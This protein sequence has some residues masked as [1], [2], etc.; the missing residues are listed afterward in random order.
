MNENYKI[1]LAFGLGVCAR[2]IS[3]PWVLGFYNE[4]YSININK[5][6]DSIFFGSMTGLIQ[7]IININNLTNIE[8]IF[9]LIFYISLFFIL[10]HA[11]TTQKFIDE[12]HLLLTLKENN[13][14]SLEYS[15]I[16][17]EKNKEL[18][19]NTQ[20]FLTEYIKEKYMTIN[21]INKLIQNN[22]L[23]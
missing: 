12:K 18:N 4:N 2:I 7:I 3:N 6:Y 14:E 23:E 5:V 22:N 15:K 19:K 13:A 1:L 10:N 16:Q 20:E 8:K 11:I 9:W 21:N 17:L